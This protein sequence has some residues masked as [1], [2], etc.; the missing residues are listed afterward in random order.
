MTWSTEIP[1]SPWVL[2]WAADSAT[3]FVLRADDELMPGSR[4]WRHV[5][6]TQVYSRDLLEQWAQRADWRFQ[7]IDIPDAP[8][9]QRSEEEKSALRDRFERELAAKRGS[10]ATI[11]PARPAD[12]EW[13][14]VP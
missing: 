6:S 14:D 8:Y 10:T 13:E 2:V 3:Y 7:P 11:I 9:R 1:D 5:G 4:W 12:D